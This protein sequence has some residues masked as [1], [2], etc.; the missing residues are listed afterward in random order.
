MQISTNVW[1]ILVVEM[2]HVE[3]LQ[4]HSAV[5]VTLATLEMDSLVQVRLPFDLQMQISQFRLYV[6]KQSQRKGVGIKRGNGMRTEFAKR[7]DYADCKNG[8]KTRIFLLYT[9]GRTHTSHKRKFI[10]KSIVAHS[11]S[12]KINF[13]L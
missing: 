3:T 12:R 1:A 13:V 4:D 5:H 9:E 7:I 6:R 8:G 11:L 2:L 10:C